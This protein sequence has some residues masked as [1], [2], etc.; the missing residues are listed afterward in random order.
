MTGKKI[1]GTLVNNQMRNGTSAALS[2]LTEMENTNKNVIS[3]K[4]K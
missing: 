1:K 2:L 4:H 3:G